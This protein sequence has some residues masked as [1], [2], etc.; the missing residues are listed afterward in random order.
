MASTSV[1]WNLVLADQPW[2]LMLMLTVECSSCTNCA[3]QNIVTRCSWVCLILW[4]MPL[5]KCM[6]MSHH[7]HLPPWLECRSTG[8]YISHLRGETAAISYSLS[9]FWWDLSNVRNISIRK[10]Q[11]KRIVHFIWGNGW[12]QFA[13]RTELLKCLVLVQLIHP[14]GHLYKWALMFCLFW[15]AVMRFSM[16]KRAM[17]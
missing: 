1:L 5:N 13:W 8:I 10:E 3:R 16:I 4:T 9:L 17:I 12:F 2:H 7:L 14:V 11:S 6:Y 15:V